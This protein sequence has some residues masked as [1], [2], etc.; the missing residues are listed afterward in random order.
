MG[1]STWQSLAR[2]SDSNEADYLNG[3]IAAIARAHGVQAP[4]NARVQALVRQA[5][6]AGKG[7]ASMTVARPALNAPSSPD[8]PTG[9]HGVPLAPILIR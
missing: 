9:C 2:G 4:L 6:S 1:G 5:S 7:P 8:A 3:E